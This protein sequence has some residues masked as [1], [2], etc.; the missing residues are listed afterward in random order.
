MGWMCRGMSQGWMMFIMGNCPEIVNKSIE[1][2][3][4]G[5]LKDVRGVF[6]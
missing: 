3:L 6:H 5:G 4:S 1:G 2:E